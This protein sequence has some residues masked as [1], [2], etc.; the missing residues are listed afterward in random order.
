MKPVKAAHGLRAML[1]RKRGRSND[2]PSPD[3]PFKR[4]PLHTGS[5]LGPLVRKS[6]TAEL[7][8]APRPS[9]AAGTLSRDYCQ[10]AASTDDCEARRLSGTGVANMPHSA[11]SASH[12]TNIRPTL[13]PSD[14]LRKWR[15]RPSSTGM[16]AVDC[17]LLVTSRLMMQSKLRHESRPPNLH[18]RCGLIVALA[19]GLALGACASS[20][21]TSSSPPRSSSRDLGASDSPPPPSGPGQRELTPAEKKIIVNAIAPSLRDA[22]TA[23]Y[24]WPKMQNAP[25]GPVNYC[26]TVNAK[27]PYPA[28][29]GRQAFIVSATVSGGKISSAV[30]GLIAGGKDFEIVRNMCKKYD[31]DPDAS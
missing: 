22:A 21:P 14:P 12:A 24:R 30:V 17:S 23:Q 28:Y 18:F 27:S 1:K 9:G 25:D 26:G 29:S 3:S 5:R 6:H 8:L 19:A 15:E 20:S 10:T 7:I 13:L 4:L 16:F 2:R 31:L 11:K